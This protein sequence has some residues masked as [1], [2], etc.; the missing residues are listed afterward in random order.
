MQ[1]EPA[2]LICAV[3]F[4]T[5]LPTP[6]LAGFAPEWITRSA[7]YFPLVGQGVGALSGVAFWL[8]SRSWPPLLSAAISKAVGILITGAFHEDGLADTVDGRFE[9]ISVP[10]VGFF[11]ACGMLYR[12][13][14]DSF[15][16]V[17]AVTRIG[18]NNFVIERAKP[19][20]IHTD[21]EPRAMS[22]KLEITL[23]PKSLRIMVPPKGTT[24]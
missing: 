3:Q 11:S 8:A 13:G 2:L 14:T 4:L 19:G 15:D 21:G 12:L 5:R 17:K 23:K 16:Q 24:V 1:R 18:G 6:T 22:S 10:R 9:L 7:K 20:W